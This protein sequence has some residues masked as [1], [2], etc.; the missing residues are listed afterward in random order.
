MDDSLHTHRGEGLI[1]RGGGTYL[2]GGG[3]R[4]FRYSYFGLRL[5]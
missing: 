4:L 1:Q 2:K 3:G 5:I